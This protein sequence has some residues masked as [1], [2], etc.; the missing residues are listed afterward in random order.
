MLGLREKDLK[1]RRQSGS[2]AL[3]LNWTPLDEKAHLVL[4]SYIITPVWSTRLLYRS[5]ALFNAL[6][7]EAKAHEMQRLE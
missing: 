1:M 2:H 5:L 3:Q 6:K 7:G 4:P